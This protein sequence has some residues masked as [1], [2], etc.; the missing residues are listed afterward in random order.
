MEV[1]LSLTNC[2]NCTL[3]L[4]NSARFQLKVWRLQ[5]GTVS[6]LWQM[7]HIWNK[8]EGK[9]KIKCVASKKHPGSALYID[10]EISNVVVFC[11]FFPLQV[12]LKFLGVLASAEHLSVFVKVFQAF[13]Q[14]FRCLCFPSYSSSILYHKITLNWNCWTLTLNRQWNLKIN[15]KSNKNLLSSDTNC[16]FRWKNIPKPVWGLHTWGEFGYGSCVWNDIW[17]VAS[18]TI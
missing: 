2:I 11:S 9:N 18:S 1:H 14:L 4:P 17:I 7:A 5:L 13:V 10:R 8:K 15:I 16:Q 6:G 3:L 12:I